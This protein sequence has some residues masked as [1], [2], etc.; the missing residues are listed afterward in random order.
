MIPRNREPIGFVRIAWFVRRSVMIVVNVDP[1]SL[2][3]QVELAHHLNGL[4][5]L[6]KIGGV[7]CEAPDGAVA[8]LLEFRARISHCLPPA[9]LRRSEGIFL[10]VE[11]P[12]G[13]GDAEVVPASRP[14]E[15]NVIVGPANLIGDLETNLVCRPQARSSRLLVFG[16][17]DELNALSRLQPRWGSIADDV[18]GGLLVLEETMD[19]A[20]GI[21]QLVP[22]LIHGK[23][24]AHDGPFVT[25]LVDGE[26]LGLLGDVGLGR[27]PSLARGRECRGAN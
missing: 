11:S 23:P 13:E 5:S 26:G 25:R 9:V 6:E 22:G 4:L 19:G 2:K 17:E 20:Q 1:A 12:L 16:N 18:N 15:V 21:L 14:E 27:A 8:S 7:R 10:I 24:W 3:S